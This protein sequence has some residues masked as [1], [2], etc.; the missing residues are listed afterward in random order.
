MNI[1][2]ELFGGDLLKLSHIKLEVS[3]QVRSLISDFLLGIG[4]QGVA[5]DIRENGIYEIS[6]YFPMDTD[7]EFVISNIIEYSDFLKQN[8]QGVYVGSVTAEHIDHSSWQVWR[9][10]LKKIKAGKNI[11]IRPPWEEHDAEDSEIVIEINPSLAFGTGHHE[12]TRLCLE[13]IEDKIER[14]K[15]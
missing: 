14:K 2:P 10:V 5:E 12:T 9:S 7:L 13:A 4:S 6:A 15:Y 8:V 11:I 3:E 1:K